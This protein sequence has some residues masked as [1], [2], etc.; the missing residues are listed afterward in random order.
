[1]NGAQLAAESVEFSPSTSL[2]QGWQGTRDRGNATL[3]LAQCLPELQP[4]EQP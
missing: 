1:M 4:Q 3:G 2:A